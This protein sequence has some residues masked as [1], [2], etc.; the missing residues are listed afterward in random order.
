VTNIALHYGIPGDTRL[1][2]DW[3]SDGVNTIGVY[4]VAD[5]GFQPGLPGDRPLAGSWGH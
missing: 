1:V 5:R 2:G 4:R 3:N